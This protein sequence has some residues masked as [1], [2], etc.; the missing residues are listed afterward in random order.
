M[1]FTCA[2][3]EL[4]DHLAIAAKATSSRPTRPIL[5]YIL[6][7][8]DAAT[9][10][11]TLTGFDEAIAI[12]TSF[13]AQ[14]EDSGTICLPAKLWGDIV[15]RLPKQA[16]TLAM[17]GGAMDAFFT[18][19]MTTGKIS[20]DVRGLSPEDYPALPTVEGEPIAIAA[21]S[22]LQGLKGALPSVS[23]D[24]S[25]Q[26]L[27]GVH[28][29]GG[30]DAIEFAATDG[31][32]LSVLQSE[33][34]TAAESLEVTVPGQALRHL[35]AMLRTH[36][37]IEPVKVYLDDVQVRFELGA[38]RLIARLLEGQYPNYRKLL[39]KDFLHQARVDRRVFIVSLERISVLA[40]TKSNIIK[41]AVASEA[42]ALS[43]DASE[44]GSGLEQ[45]PATVQGDAIDIAF[46]ATYLLD[47]LRAIE[48][49]EV[50]LLMNT[51]VSPAVLR[52]AQGFAPLGTEPR[53]LIMPVQ[54]RS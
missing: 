12:A 51:P 6:V 25:K 38:R 49:A 19:A 50:E 18:V 41:I 10:A 21:L 5:S 11:V 45:L 37:A 7:V 3:S 30:S 43:V 17:G 39:P 42:I 22:L 46:N 9:Q 33:S 20:Y 36:D 26:V 27:M 44:I 1:K 52:P 48:S 40:A 2:Q 16:V 4:N 14:V 47:G 23:D 8:A 35:E 32:R 28:L 54:I 31:H 53:Y 29:L 34:D 13:T 24:E 15:S